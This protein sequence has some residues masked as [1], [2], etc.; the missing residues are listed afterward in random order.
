MISHSYIPKINQK[1]L[2]E[3]SKK[4]E[5]VLLT[6]KK[7]KHTLK[8]YELEENEKISIIP[9]KI[10][11][12]G[13]FYMFLNLSE[14]YDI[15][16]DIIHIEE[17]PWSLSCFQSVRAGKI[18]NRKTILFT[19]ENIYKNFLPPLSFFEKYNLKHADYAISGNKDAKKVLI[20]KGFSKPIK[21]LPQLGIDPATFKPQDTSYIKDRLNLDGFV[22]G[23]VGRLVHEKGLSTLIDAISKIKQEY[24]L[25]IVGGGEIKRDIVELAE[26][27]DLKDKIR[28]VDS[29][30]HAEVSKYLSCMDVLVLP[31]IT[32]EKWKEQFGHVLIEAMSCEVPVIGSN[33]GEI[34][35]VIGDAGLVFKEKDATE[36]AEKIKILMSDENLR[37][38]LAKKGRKR[39][40]K[41]YTWERIAEETYKIYQQ[42][43]V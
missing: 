23:F 14:L 42:L 17:E 18:L 24:T 3:L 39:V 20:K 28:F 19:W 38:S 4:V 37:K 27:L 41:N 26:K 2:E 6:P 33:S 1:K 9:K 16:P 43:L 35:N 29:I 21:V 36:L 12:K 7:W 11:L 13:S 40:L 10:I 5:L 32:T 15:K 31:S 22:I 25:L 34:P 8:T 30:P